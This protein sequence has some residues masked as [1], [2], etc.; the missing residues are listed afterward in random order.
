MREAAKPL[1][2]V[3]MHPSGYYMAASFID[4]IRIYHILNDEFKHFQNID[5]RYCKIMKFSTGGHLFACLNDDKILIFNAY[6]LAKLREI[7]LG[8]NSKLIQSM[9]FHENDKALTVTGI[10]NYIAR[11]EMPHFK[12]VY[13]SK[14]VAYEEKEDGSDI[15]FKKN[16]IHV[17]YETVT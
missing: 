5:I 8:Q 17:R 2:S 3:A 16:K 13:E 9:I 12:K 11:W 7:E 4:K 10:N 15:V 6:T 1:L 14:M